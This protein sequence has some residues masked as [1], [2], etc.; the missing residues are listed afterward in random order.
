L[1]TTIRVAFFPEA[2]CFDPRG[3]RQVICAAPP[4][5]TLFRSARPARGATRLGKRSAL[6]GNVSIRAPRAGRD[7]SCS[8]YAPQNTCFDPRA[9]RGARLSITETLSS[10]NA[11]RSAR[12]A[13]GA[14]SVRARRTRASSS[15]DPRAPRGARPFS[16]RH[17]LCPASFDPRAPRGARPRSA[18]EA[19]AE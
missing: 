3:A 18:F 11:F 4:L 12:P 19:F 13:R 1:Y 10:T 9:P 16:R 2:R 5:L 17:R 15:F 8:R 7:A 6:R 14:T